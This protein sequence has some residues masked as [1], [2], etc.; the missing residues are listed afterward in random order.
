MP[1]TRSSTG[2]TSSPPRCSRHSFCTS[3]SASPTAVRP[4]HRAGAAPWSHFSTFPAY[5]RR[6]AAGLGHRSLVRQRASAAPP[7]QDRLRL[8]GRLLR[9]G[10]RHLLRARPPHRVPAAAPAA[11]VAY[12]RHAGR[13]HSLHLLLRRSFPPRHASSRRCCQ[14]SS[15][16]PWS[17]CPSPSRWAIV[18]YR[19][20][21]VDLI[22]KRGVTYTL[23][24]AA[25]VGLYFGVVAV[26][27]E[28]STAACPSS[29]ASGACSPPS[30]RPASSLI[31][32]SAP[33]RPASTASSTR[34]ASTTAKPSSTSAARSTL[35]R[36]FA[37]WSTPSSS[38]FHRP[39]SSPASPSS[40]PHET[41]RRASPPAPSF[42]LAASHGLTQP[43]DRRT[44][45]LDLRFLDFDAPDANSHVF[46]ENPQQVLRLK[47]PSARRPPASTSTT[48]CPAASRTAPADGISG[49]HPHR[50]HHR[51]RP[52]Q[53]RRLPLVRRH[54]SAGVA[55]RLH[56]HRHPERPALPHARVQDQRVRAAERLQPEHRRIHQHRH[57]RRRSR[58]T[59]SRAGTRRWRSCSPARVPTPSASRSSSILPA[60]FMARFDALA[61]TPR[62]RRHTFTSSASRCPP[63]KPAPPTSPSRPCS[64][65]PSTSSAASS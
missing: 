49:R 36:I 3:P 51:P 29:P 54:G 24:T 19:L 7:R 59:A 16:S 48:T 28:P 23:A 31:P 60:D 43:Q 27:A 30:S 38:A 22:F 45:T 15:A 37:P 42:E 46:L 25:L 34:S 32:S 63:A 1:S 10:S 33:S 50:R 6:R 53:R 41:A 21:D 61:A 4:P 40:S 57:L 9:V 17:S 62:P 8:H 52:H 44:Q 64:R 65:A 20:M 56:R 58:T 35:R 14:N 2:A 47:T 5:L 12:A 13:G 55:R 11:Q 26:T 39:C 18:R